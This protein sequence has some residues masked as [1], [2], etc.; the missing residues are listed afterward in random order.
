MDVLKNLD[1]LVKQTSIEPVVLLQIEYFHRDVSG[2]VTFMHI[3]PA[4]Q[5]QILRKGI[6]IF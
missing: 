4:I 1:T 2:R 6:L 5:F 3:E